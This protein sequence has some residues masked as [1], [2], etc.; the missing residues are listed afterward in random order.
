[1]RFF[2]HSVTYFT[3]AWPTHVVAAYVRGQGRSLFTRS[4]GAVGKRNRSDPFLPSVFP[5]VSGMQ[6]S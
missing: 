1:M 5:D 4:F 6:D 2:S 3:L